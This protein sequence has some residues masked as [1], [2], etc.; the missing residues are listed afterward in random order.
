MPKSPHDQHAS[1]LP[2]AGLEAADLH[3]GVVDAGAV[4]TFEVGEDDLAVVE[5]HLGVVTA[6]ALVV[7]AQEVA[8]FAADG[9]RR[10]QVA[11]DAALVDSVQHPKGNS[12]HRSTLGT[13]PDSGP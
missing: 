11:E 2:V 13:C 10:R 3:D 5:L 1:S 8:L 4:G 6:D 7:E 12:R 9:H